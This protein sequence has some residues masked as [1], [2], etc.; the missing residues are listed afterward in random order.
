VRVSALAVPASRTE[1]ISKEAIKVHIKYPVTGKGLPVAGINAALFCRHS[2][3][4]RRHNSE[5]KNPPQ[6]N[7]G[8]FD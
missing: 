5:N 7:S 4:R 8:R 1:Q 2:K 6:S 3:N